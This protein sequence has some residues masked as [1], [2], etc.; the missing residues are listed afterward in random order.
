MTAL[1]KRL[2]YDQRQSL[3]GFLF[4]APIVV[5]YSF[6]ALWPMLNA[7]YLSFFK[8][9][10]LSKPEFVG[11]SQYI[12]L[13][14]TPTF[15]KSLSVTA[16]YVVAVNVPVWILSISV[17]MVL[18]TKI[19]GRTFFRTLVFSP[20]VMPLA[21][22]AVIWSLLYN[23]IGPINEWI[24]KSFLD[25]PLP[26]LNSERLALLAVIVM[27]IWRAFGYYSVLF[28]AGLQNI[29]TEFYEAA[30]IDGAGPWLIF[31]RITWPLLRPT[32]LFVIIISVTNTLRH[33]DAIWIM[34]KGGPVDATRVL[35]ILIYETGW[36][37][38][39][40][41]KASAMSVFLLV[42]L[43]VF[44]AIQFKLFKSSEYE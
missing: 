16:I 31:S 4:I 26:W 32:T 40:M 2:R 28:L 37:Y 13:I 41:G 6:F 20:I 15:L 1:P 36:T 33:F 38:F 27:A 24:L 44:S 3:Y 11:I 25:S 39:S 35:S 14:K 18:N 30:R 7:V 12:S 8:Y 21:V 19:R 43:L 9:D 34:T 17:A 5:Y 10:L 22:L 23:P 42:A 29:S